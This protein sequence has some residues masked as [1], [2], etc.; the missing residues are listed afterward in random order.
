LSQLVT[1]AMMAQRSARKQGKPAHAIVPLSELGSAFPA[2]RTSRLATLG[3]LA[4]AKSGIGKN[5]DVERCRF[6]FK[7]ACLCTCDVRHVTDVTFS[8]PA[9]WPTQSI[10]WWCR[11]MRRP[12]PTCITSRRLRPE[13]MRK[14]FST[15][16]SSNNS[17]PKPTVVLAGWLGSQ[18]SKL[19]RYREFYALR[20]HATILRIATPAM[21]VSGKP[22]ALCPRVPV[23][24]RG[25]SWSPT[26]AREERAAGATDSSWELKTMHDLAWDTLREL[27]GQESPRFVVHSFSNGGCFLYEQIQRIL[28]TRQEQQADSDAS[29][30]LGRLEMVGAVFDSCPGLDLSTLDGA[31]A[32]CSAEELEQLEAQLPNY[33]TDLQQHLGQRQDE[34]RQHMLE[35]S[36]DMP[37]LYIYS[38][39][40]LLAPFA[41]LDQLVEE[42]AKNAL[43]R[44]RSRQAGQAPLF[45]LGVVRKL[46]LDDSPHCAHY[47]YHRDQYEAALDSFLALLGS[48]EVRIDPSDRSKL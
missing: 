10:M 40:D 32:Y 38:R 27:H 42:R 8:P 11:T 36:P 12:L 16:A 47:L 25:L 44:M 34:F 35:T 1:N 28:F 22:N 6:P 48:G 20:G 19:R 17:E 26:D 14:S 30:A 15:A 9:N 7:G 5:L 46:V 33:R 29:K 13:P 31:L 37:Q 23:Q 3:A 2:H 41:P 21:V 4:F 45:P 43:R 24:P 18:P 39:N